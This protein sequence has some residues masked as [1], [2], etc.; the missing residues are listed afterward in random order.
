MDHTTRDERLL[1]IGLGASGRAAARE[2]LAA[3]FRVTATARDP[4]LAGMA[5]VA[6]IPFAEAA[7]AIAEATHL[8]VTA[9]PGE[10]EGDPAIAAHRAALREAG[11]LRWIG[12]VSTTGVYGDRGGAW[13]DETAAPAPGQP[14]SRR[15][16]A[17]EQAWRAIAAGRALDLFRTAGIYGAKRSVFEDL[18]AG[19]ARRILAPDHDFGRIHVADMGRALIAAAGRTPPPGVRVLHL[20]DD[21]PAPPSEVI[22]EAARLLGIEPPPARPLAELWPEMS[23]MARSFWSESRRL[24]NDI[25]KQALGLAWRYPSYREGLA[26]VLAAESTS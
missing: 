6:V 20:T 8:L 13:L 19:T 11:R 2:A 17:A 21:L 1:V 16:L 3:G 10:A 14:R 5:G 25:T 15:R 23:P 9:P 24:R 26:A 12:Y 4:T 22:A 18:R 7:A